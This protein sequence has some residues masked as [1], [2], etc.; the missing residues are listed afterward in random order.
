MNALRTVPGV[1]LSP[2]RLPLVAR[3]VAAVLACAVLAAGVTPAQAQIVVGG[4]G[5]NTT[6]STSYS[7]TQ[8]LTKI[9]T[10]TV[11]LTGANS[12]TGATNV[13]DGTLMI[14][15][16]NVL[17]DTSPVV[18]NA[19]AIF[20]T[21]SFGDYIGSLSLTGNA[22]VAGT[23]G[24]ILTQGASGTAS[25]KTA[26]ATG[27]DNL[28]ASNI[29]ISSSHGGVGGNSTLRFDVQGPSDTLR[30]TG[31]IADKSFDGGGSATTGAISKI[32]NGTLTF[33]GSNT[34]SGETFINAGTVVAANNRALGA[35]GVFDATKTT[36]AAGATL[37]LQGTISMD[38]HMHIFG[39]GVG[40][41]GAIRN[42]SGSNALTASGYALRSDVTVGAD[43]GQLTIAGAIGQ[44][45]GVYGVTKV[46][47][48]TL[49]L[50]GVNTWS[51]GTRVDAGDLVIGAGGTLLNSGSAL[52]VNNG[53]TVTFARQDVLGF[54]T[55]TIT[56]PI[57]LNDGGLLQNSGSFFNTLGALTLNGGTLQANAVQ[58]ASGQSFAL[59]GTVTVAGTSTSTITGNGIALGAASV[60]GTTFV[61]NDGSAAA[62]LL[63]T[64]VLR[65][66]SGNTFGT[67]QASSLTKAG[68][69]TMVLTG[70]N[71]YSGTTTVS[72][73]TLVVNGV[74]STSNTTVAAGAT[75]AGSGTVG[76]GTGGTTAT[77][78]G[79]HS[80]GS[81]VGVQTV[82]SDLIYQA[83]SSLLWDL[84][85]NTSN[86][87]SFDQV[88]MP[89]SNLNFSGS[90]TLTMSFDGAGSTVNWADAFWNDDRSWIV[91]DHADLGLG[92]TTGFGNLTLGGSLLDSQGNSLS[93]TG[94][95]YFTL[96]QSGADVVL[97]FTAVP[98]P[99][100]VALA[101]FGIA[102]AGLA[103]RRRKWRSARAAAVVARGVAA[104]LAC[105]VL[106][107]SLAPAQAQTTLP[108]SIAGSAFVDPASYSTGTS[109][110][111]FKR[112]GRP[113]ALR[114]ASAERGGS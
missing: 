2:R 44:Q 10:N 112:I 65:D 84:A 61:V 71:T 60:N 21:G 103:A 72:A 15:A 5:S 109:G 59:K 80:P 105:A 29:G 88:L 1:P 14:G 39:S 67:S 24:F 36:V 111:T 74:N 50:G 13:N 104:V 100:S 49:V 42:L 90:T 33:S 17:P 30:I 7:G 16:N 12:Y 108:A 86:A 57:V 51:G 75:L 43:D 38:E 63:V 48:G 37:A 99:S 34:Y 56:M 91:W 93:P 47:A 77:I 87:G 85:G 52:T 92:S 69:G 107:A 4:N 81:S 45:G 89:G 78:A 11:T 79:I 40:G 62:D 102:A 68:A 18:V 32:G 96:G 26:T 25:L 95:G 64:G 20:S 114:Q 27:T 22:S 101:A 110:V 98:E 19:G 55:A 3:G 73:G 58:P 8:S 31:V 54:H 41:L 82:F 46:G 6:D 23:G 53:A 9:G 106:A 113:M 97:N 35:G 76:S 70:S 66:G 83:G 28:I 94:R